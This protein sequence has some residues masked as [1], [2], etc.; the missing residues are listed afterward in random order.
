MKA[1]LYSFKRFALGRPAQCSCCFDVF[2]FHGISGGKWGSSMRNNLRYLSERFPCTCWNWLKTIMLHR[3]LMI[4][5]V[6]KLIFFPSTRLR[7]KRAA[8]L[9]T[10]AHTCSV[11]KLRCS[12]ICNQFHQNYL[13]YSKS[14]RKTRQQIILIASSTKKWNKIFFPLFL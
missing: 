14:K 2:I 11:Y 12:L 10:L 5:R 8:K 6:F 4:F 3:W 9:N 13:V 7:M 1:V